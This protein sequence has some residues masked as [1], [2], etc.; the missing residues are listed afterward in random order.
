MT[1][2]VSRPGHGAPGAADERALRKV[3]LA[4]LVRAYAPYSRFRV[5][6]ALVAADGRVFTGCNVENASYGGAICAERGAVMA[7]VV[8]GAR[9]FIRL[10]VATE[11][12]IPTPPCGLCRQVLIE[13]APSLEVVSVTTGGAEAS[14]TLAE[15]LPDSFTPAHLPRD[16]AR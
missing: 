8:A 4:A 15:L 5:G 13:F 14:W 3:A 7:A 12:E 1:R 9:K 6:A 11:A 10:V 2:P 16:D